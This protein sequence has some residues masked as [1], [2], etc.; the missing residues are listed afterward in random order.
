M[1]RNISYQIFFLLF[2]LVNNLCSDVSRN[3]CPYPADLRFENLSETIPSAKVS[4]IYQDSQGFL[5]FGTRGDGIIRYNGMNCNVYRQVKGNIRDICEQK[6]PGGR[7]LWITS[8]AHGL[9]K[10]NLESEEFSHFWSDSA[11]TNSLN[12][13]WLEKLYVHDDGSLWIGTWWGGLNILRP[14]QMQAEKPEF[15]HFKHIPAAPH[16]VYK[17]VVKEIYKDKRDTLWLGTVCGI[18]KMVSGYKPG[19]QLKFNY[20]QVL[21][22]ENMYDTYPVVTKIIEDRDHFL[23][24]CASSIFKS[25]Q[26]LPAA[27]PLRFKNYFPERTDRPGCSDMLEDRRGDIWAPGTNIVKLYNRE[28]DS[29]ISYIQDDYD[30]DSYPLASPGCIFEDKSGSLWFGGWPCAAKLSPYKQNFNNFVPQAGNDQSLLNKRVY[31]ICEDGSGNLWI[32]TNAALTATLTRFDPAEKH[33]KHFIPDPAESVIKESKSILR[34]IA[35]DAFDK[36]YLW[37]ANSGGFLH[38]L[39]THDGKCTHYSV[40]AVLDIFPS[41]SGFIWITGRKGIQKF[42]PQSGH[43]DYITGGGFTVYSVYEDTHENLWAATATRGL[44]KYDFLKDQQFWYKHDPGDSTTIS[45]NNIVSIYEDK[46][47]SMWFGT[48]GGGL[49]KFNGINEIFTT[50]SVEDGLAN[51]YVAGILEDDHGYLWIS[52][53]NGL[54]KFNP[55]DCSFKNYY[56]SD[57]IAGT[58]FI[59]R[60]CFKSP[61]S[62]YL[63]FGSSEGCTY[64]HPDSIKENPHLPDVRIIDFKVFNKSVSPGKNSALK[65]SISY[66]EDIVLSYTQSVFSFE[67]TA[68]EF[69]RFQMFDLQ[70]MIDTDTFE[71]IPPGTDNTCR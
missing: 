17:N 66:C 47:G 10:Y 31:S 29:F 33:F 14:E 46:N 58:V 38:K 41:R 50:Y 22:N 24:V 60:S 2:F 15:L 36:N 62:G 56:K 69:I 71:L 34:R 30:P 28:T 45:L 6:L 23:W 51:N 42:Y 11:D 70:L 55:L 27:K 9:W 40:E 57:G 4:C 7:V 1:K 37:V 67:F 44:L 19:E 52:T 39:D 64:F 61:S 53:R 32:A 18:S 13:D 12:C 16:S 26:P 20:Y 35:A 21:Q 68:L 65:K 43:T 59:D 48:G 8:L 25:T 54:S 3:K 49:N 5:W 63:F